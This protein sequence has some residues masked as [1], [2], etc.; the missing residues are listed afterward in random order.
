MSLILGADEKPVERKTPWEK[1]RTCRWWDRSINNPDVGLCHG[2]PPTPMLVQ[3]QH[4]I[5]GQVAQVMRSFWGETGATDGCAA[6]KPADTIETE[7]VTS[8]MVPKVA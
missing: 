6:H 5:T 2:G 3:M 7:A 8:S 4:K 1:C